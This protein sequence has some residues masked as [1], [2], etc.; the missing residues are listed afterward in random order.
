[1]SSSFLDSLGPN[2]RSTK[3]KLAIQGRIRIHDLYSAIRLVT[4][5]RVIMRMVELGM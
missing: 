5:I 2:S 3:Q 4:H 1:M